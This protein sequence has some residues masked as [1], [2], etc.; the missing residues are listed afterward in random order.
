MMLALRTMRMVAAKVRPLFCGLTRA[1]AYTG[2]GDPVRDRC[3]GEVAGYRRAS[4]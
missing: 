4:T 1:G 3:G 2:A